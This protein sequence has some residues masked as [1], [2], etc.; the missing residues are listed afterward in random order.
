MKKLFLTF[1]IAGAL[2]AC[3]NEGESTS[4]N[5][6]SAR[7]ADSIRVADSIRNAMPPVQTPGTGDSLN[8]SGSDSLKNGKDSVSK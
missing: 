3:N 5:S 8:Q 4:T 7:I 6:D 2:V 1:A